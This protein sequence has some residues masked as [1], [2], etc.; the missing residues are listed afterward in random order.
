MKKER[1]ETK[2]IIETLKYA[3][4]IVIA[5]G[6]PFFGTKLL[7]YTLDEIIHMQKADRARRNKYYKSL[8]YLE[9]KKYIS[10]KKKGGNKVAIK[11]SPAGIKKSKQYEFEELELNKPEKWDGKWRIIIFDIKSGEKRKR[12]QIRWKLKKWNFFMLQKSVW[13]C[14]YDLFK[15]AEILRSHF[16]LSRRELKIITAT[17]IEDEQWIKK[18]FKLDQ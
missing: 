6:S 3:G 8:K 1:K 7:Q 17:H 14:P 9:Q 12:E 16:S 5:M 2:E 4:E 10:I 18:H 11:L 15:E 13:V